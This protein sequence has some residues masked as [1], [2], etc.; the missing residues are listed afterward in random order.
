MVR[1]KNPCFVEAQR[2]FCE[3]HHIVYGVVLPAELTE[4]KAETFTCLYSLSRCVA[5]G[6]RC[7]WRAL[8]VAC[9]TYVLGI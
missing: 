6:V 8:P 5:C 3:T 4:C 2:E 7:L 1:N 9:V